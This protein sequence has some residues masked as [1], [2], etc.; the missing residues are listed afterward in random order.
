MNIWD[1]DIVPL[2]IIICVTHFSRIYSILFKDNYAESRGYLSNKLTRA[3][4]IIESAIWIMFIVMIMVKKY[5]RLTN[6]FDNYEN[7]YDKGYLSIVVAMLFNYFIVT[8]Y[9]KQYKVTK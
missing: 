9:I 8:Q 5:L 1:F 3:H 7:I 2:V 4:L 6:M